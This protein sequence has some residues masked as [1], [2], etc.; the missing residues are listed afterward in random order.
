MLISK[1]SDSN[2]QLND[3]LSSEETLSNS[4]SLLAAVESTYLKIDSITLKLGDKRGKGRETINLCIESV[5]TA[6]NK[7]L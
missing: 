2:S 7:L 5:A 6:E 4:C 1:S 3:H